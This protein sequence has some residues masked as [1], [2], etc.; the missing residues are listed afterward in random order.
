MAE[1]DKD[2]LDRQES[3]EGGDSGENGGTVEKSDWDRRKFMK[4]GTAVGAGLLSAPA[5]AAEGTGDGDVDGDADDGDR[6]DVDGAQTTK[7]TVQIIMAPT[8]FQGIIMDHLGKDT[9]ILKNNFK[10]NNFQIETARSWESAAI[11]TSGGADLGT[12]GSLEAAKLAGERDLPLQVNANMAPQF[13]CSVVKNGGPYDPE[14]TGSAQ[15]SMDKLQKTQDRYA[16]GGWGGGTGVMM[17]LVVKEAFGYNF[18]DG[19]KSDFKNI[20]T[21]EYAAVPQLVNEGRAVMGT[22]SPLHGAAPTMAPKEYDGDDASITTCWQLGGA[23]EKLENFSAPQ[24]NS[25]TCSQKYG[26]KYPAAP[27]T[28]VQTFQTG[29]DWLYEDPT[30][31]MEASDKHLRQLGVENM[32]QARYVLDWGINLKLDNDLQVIYED[33]GLTEEFVKNDK[34]FLATAAET[35]FLSDDWEEKLKYRM[36]PTPE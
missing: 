16:L 17:P 33:I 7:D 29:V 32:D 23:M 12:L 28:M 6:G 8:G 9:D 27:K 31:R 3:V 30:G 15:A 10:E 20:V 34:N 5:A 4:A 26:S 2:R 14:N 36:V 13:M 19:P 35:G 22:S 24:L 25:W 21:A 18:T 1:D 11:F